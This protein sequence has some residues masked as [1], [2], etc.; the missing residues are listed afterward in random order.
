MVISILDHE[1]NIA[2]WVDLAE[3]QK[4]VVRWWK[5]SPPKDEDVRLNPKLTPENLLDVLSAKTRF[6]AFTHTSNIMGTIHDVKAITE[7]VRKHSPDALVCVDAVAYA[8]HRKIDV[9]GLG[10]DF[11]AFSWYKV[12]VICVLQGS[13]FLWGLMPKHLGVWPAYLDAIRKPKGTSPDAVLGPL[14]QQTRYTR[15]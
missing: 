8:P 14:L 1:A 9:K 12:G 7:T 15:G 11:Y 3:R 6:V 10:V 2:S 4:L 13:V 5:P